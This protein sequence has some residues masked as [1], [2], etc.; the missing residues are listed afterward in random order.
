[1][2]GGGVGEPVGQGLRPGA[3]D[4]HVAHHVVPE[5]LEARQTPSLRFREEYEAGE[6]LHHRGNGHERV[7][8]YADDVRGVDPTHVRGDE[9]ALVTP[10]DP[11]AFVAE[12]A[13]QLGEGAR[14]ARVSPSGPAERP[15][16]AVA[17][18]RWN[19]EVESVGRVTAAR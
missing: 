12:P 4:L 5:M 17:R 6:N 10:L 8:V 14:D 11:I 7:D 9:R 15:G 18:N 13:H 3:L 1:M 16:E 19:H 2:A